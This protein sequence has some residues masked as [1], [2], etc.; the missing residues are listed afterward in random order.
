MWKD[1]DRL[2]SSL[3]LESRLSLKHLLV[4]HRLGMIRHEIRLRG[5]TICQA[6]L[7][8]PSYRVFIV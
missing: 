2:R 6:M 1:M 4:V 3:E 7:K 8:D 5:M